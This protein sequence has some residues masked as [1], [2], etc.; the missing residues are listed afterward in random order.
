MTLKS[1]EKSIETSLSTL[2]EQSEREERERLS[3]LASFSDAAS[4]HQTI[5]PC[6]Y[7]TAFQRDR[8]R[9]LHS[10]AFRRLSHKTQVFIS[11][12]G[13]HYRT[14]LTHSLEVAQIA[15]TVARALRLNEDLTEAIALGHDLG[16]PPFGHT[17]ESILAGLS[18]NV[19]WHHES[20]SVRI[21][22]LLEPLNLSTQ[23]REGMSNQL[24]K[25]KTKSLEALVVKI[26]DRMTYL[27]HDME[28]ASRAGLIN[29][30]QVPKEIQVALGSTRSERL[31][32]MV[33]DLIEQS[34]LRLKDNQPEIVMSAPIET[35][36]NQLRKWMHESVYLSPVQQ[37]ERDKVARVLQGLY[38]WYVEHPEM[39]PIENQDSD[40][41]PVDA[42]DVGEVLDTPNGEI[43]QRVI[44]FLAGMTD[45]FAIEHYRHMLLPKPYRSQ[46]N[47][48]VTF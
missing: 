26:T 6:V 34:Q 41:Q 16:H 36:M 42:L 4:H 39:L 48:K 35:A 5:T 23:T 33:Q 18:P 1:T 47:E 20:H 28:D 7:R 44:D 37:A 40:R 24:N 43:S 38:Q 9:I 21:V 3:P 15:R 30:A 29:E 12:A 22:T 8:D 13:D 11:P 27:H 10:K 17:G 19:T 2:R 14:R 25:K 31:N 32:T 46:M 45:R